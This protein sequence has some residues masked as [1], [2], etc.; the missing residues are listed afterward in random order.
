MEMLFALQR[1]ESRYYI[2]PPTND[3]MALASQTDKIDR[4]QMVPFLAGQSMPHLDDFQLTKHPGKREEDAAS[5]AKMGHHFWEVCSIPLG[6]ILWDAH[7][8][9]LNARQ[10]RTVHG[11]QYPRSLDGK[12][13]ESIQRNQYCN[14]I[15]SQTPH[16]RIRF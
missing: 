10:A 3:A 9:K 11:L 1:A 6:M 8:W 2:I 12:R 13:E 16:D 14:S 15:S 7:L 5:R 4:R